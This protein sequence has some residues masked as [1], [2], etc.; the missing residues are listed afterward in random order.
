MRPMLA[1][2]VRRNVA[3][4]SCRGKIEQPSQ[5]QR[6]SVSVCVRVFVS[7]AAAVAAVLNRI[8]VHVRTYV[9]VCS[10]IGWRPSHFPTSVVR[11]CVRT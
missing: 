9:R 7:L 4:E 11:A 8:I 6:M 10:V 1:V 5:R 3:Y 2:S